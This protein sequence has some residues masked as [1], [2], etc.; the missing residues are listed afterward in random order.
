M[1]PEL[2]PFMQLVDSV[3]E[4]NLDNEYFSTEDLAQGVYLCRM[5]LYRR[6]LRETNFSASKYIRKYRLEKAGE[7]LRNTALSISDISYEVGFSWTPYFNKCFKDWFGVCPGYY[8][9]QVRN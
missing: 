5:Q 2:N 9:S 3:I 6:L 4:Q 7:L 8:R 1:K